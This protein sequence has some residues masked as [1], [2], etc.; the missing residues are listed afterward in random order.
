MN[1]NKE[2]RA[3]IEIDIIFSEK[4][5]C[6]SIK[7]VKKPIIRS[8]KDSNSIIEATLIFSAE[9]M[10]HI[11]RKV[12]QLMCSSLELQLSLKRMFNFS[13]IITKMCSYFKING[14]RQ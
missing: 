5:G 3:R 9:Q 8:E 13:Y 4:D 14:K 12:F 1:D 11:P 10:S 6:I 7:E 2:I